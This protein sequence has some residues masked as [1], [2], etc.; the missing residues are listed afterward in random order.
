VEIDTQSEQMEWILLKFLKDSL[1]FLS[2]PEAKGTNRMEWV[3][4]WMSELHGER[5][6]LWMPREAATALKQK[7]DAITKEEK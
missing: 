3:K 7:W 4:T 1:D 6:K 5:V 2:K